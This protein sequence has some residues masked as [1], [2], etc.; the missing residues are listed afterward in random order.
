MIGK[1]GG[2]KGSDRQLDLPRLCER[3]DAMPMRQ[4]EM[5]GTE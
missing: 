1:D 3:I 2:L 5:Q 4:P